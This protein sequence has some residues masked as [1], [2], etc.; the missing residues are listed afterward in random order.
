MLLTARFAL[1]L[2]FLKLL[3]CKPYLKRSKHREYRE[4]KGSLKLDSCF[5]AWYFLYRKAYLHQIWTMNEFI[6]AGYI[7][8][9]KSLYQINVCSGQVKGLLRY[10]CLHCLLVSWQGWSTGISRSQLVGTTINWEILILLW[11]FPKNCSCA[12]LSFEY[13]VVESNGSLGQRS[14]MKHDLKHG[15]K[16]GNARIYICDATGQKEY[17]LRMLK[18]LIIKK[19]IHAGKNTQLQ[20]ITIHWR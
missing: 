3:P 14:G 6:I 9:A 1:T 16:E 4:K 13:S 15:F 12:F 11:L 2:C 17:D 5:K 19:W 8:S 20:I 18:V 7:S 10:H